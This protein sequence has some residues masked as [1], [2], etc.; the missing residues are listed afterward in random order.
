MDFAALR[1][2]QL[3]AVLQGASDVTTGKADIFFASAKKLSLGW[4]AGSLQ[5]AERAVATDGLPRSSPPV[6]PVHETSTGV[7]ILREPTRRR[8]E[9]AVAAVTKGVLFGTERGDSV[10]LGNMPTTVQTADAQMTVALREAEDA[11]FN[12]FAHSAGPLRR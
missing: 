2:A 8:I 10:A 6:P 5:R 1:P 11:L 12:R 3:R 9:S 7:T 4:V